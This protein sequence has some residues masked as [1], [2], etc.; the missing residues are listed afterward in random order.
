MSHRSND[1]PLRRSPLALLAPINRCG[2]W[3]VAPCERMTTGISKCLSCEGKKRTPKDSAWTR[4]L[5]QNQIVCSNCKIV[6]IAATL[7]QSKQAFMQDCFAHHEQASAL[8]K[9][10][11]MMSS[12]QLFRF[13]HPPSPHG[14]SP[15]TPKEAGGR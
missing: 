7:Y 15:T 5:Y 13:L 4:N 3:S 12:L 1:N 11:R 2:L 6:R 14:K 8:S 9:Q 10:N